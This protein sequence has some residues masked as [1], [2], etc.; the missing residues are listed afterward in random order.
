MEAWKNMRACRPD[1]AMMDLGRDQEG[2]LIEFSRRDTAS[3]RMR[4][5]SP[6]WKSNV[7]ERLS[8][9]QPLQLAGETPGAV[10]QT[11]ALA[12]SRS[13]PSHL[14]FNPSMFLVGP[15]RGLHMTCISTLRRYLW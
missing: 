10:M 11:Y 14:S 4:Q 12:A 2:V 1:N 7:E 6:G 3:L 8:V 15:V 13:L 5:V 9:R